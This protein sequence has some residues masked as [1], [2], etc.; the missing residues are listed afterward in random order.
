MKNR[1]ISCTAQFHLKTINNHYF[2]Y[3]GIP[4][5]QM[6]YQQLYTLGMQ[7]ITGTVVPK[8]ILITQG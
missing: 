1:R 7:I 3:I 6:L 8:N 2:M 4:T 5:K